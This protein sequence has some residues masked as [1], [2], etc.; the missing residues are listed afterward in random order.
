M[1]PVLYP[2]NKGH[3]IT[4][5]VLGMVQVFGVDDP[6]TLAEADQLANCF[7]GVGQLENAERLHRRI[8]EV[9]ESASFNRQH[10]VTHATVFAHMA[11]LAEILD[12]QGKVL[13]AEVQYQAALVFVQKC[14]GTRHEL[15]AEVMNSLGNLLRRGGKL[16]QAETLLW[17][18]F[19]IRKEIRGGTLG[20]TAIAASL[21]NLAELKRDQGCF[22]AA[23]PLYKSA[24]HVLHDAVVSGKPADGTYVPDSI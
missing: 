21:N 14:F 23:L 19:E 15:A 13:E 3:S 16:E 10:T 7:K 9:Y 20:A 5:R 4:T 12:Q 24:L 18:S 6:R 11:Q 8:V 17:R 22:A 1:Y 2:I